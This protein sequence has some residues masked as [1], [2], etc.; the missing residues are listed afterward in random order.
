MVEERE[1]KIKREKVQF[2]P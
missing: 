2:T 1:R